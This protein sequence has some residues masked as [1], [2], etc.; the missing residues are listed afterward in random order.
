VYNLDEFRTSALSHVS[1]ARCN[2][3][4]VLKNGRAQSVYAILTYKTLSGGHGC[5]GRDL[6][7]VRNMCSHLDGDGRLYRFRR[8]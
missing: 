6:N 4:E 8:V 7:A 5:I 2:N 3:L 1:E